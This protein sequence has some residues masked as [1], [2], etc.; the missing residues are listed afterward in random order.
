M[1]GQLH[2][3]AT[4]LTSE[5]ASVTARRWPLWTAC[6]VAVVILIAHV[7]AGQPE[8]LDPLLA[9]DLDPP[10]M[11]LFEVLW[12]VS[13]LLLATFPVALGWAA[14]ADQAVAR[15]VLV[16]VWV[17]CAGFAAIFFTVDVAAF[18]SA[19]LT[20]PQWTLFLPILGLVPM[21]ANSWSRVGQPTEPEPEANQRW[22]HAQRP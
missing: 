17:M 19:V 2:L 11:Q 5:P 15:P 12:H 14:R 8:N 4:E 6:G 1:R 9:S 7:A 22:D 10:I 16:Y 20:L 13:T 18:G 3:R 21:A